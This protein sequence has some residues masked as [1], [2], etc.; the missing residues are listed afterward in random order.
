MIIKIVLK[1]GEVMKVTKEDDGE[2]FQSWVERITKKEFFAG[3]S[4]AI[5]TREIELIEKVTD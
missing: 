4:I 2:S 1:S 3:T 5:N